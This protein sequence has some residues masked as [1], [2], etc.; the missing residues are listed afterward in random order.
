[1]SKELGNV[2]LGGGSGFIGKHLTSL[3]TSKGYNVTIIS[4]MPGASRISWTDLQTKGLPESTTAVINLAGQNVMDFTQRWTTGF[5][6]NVFNSRVK[7]TASLAEAIAKAPKRPKVFVAISGVGAYKPNDKEYTESSILENFDFFSK[8]CIE[9]EKAACL[10]KEVTDCRQVIIRSGVVLG[11]DG[12]M[13]KQLYLPFFLGLGG[14]VGSGMQYMPWIHIDDLTRLILFSIENNVEGVYN[15][16]APTPATNKEFS[17]AFA[18][19]LSRPAI[20][21]VPKFVF[22]A[23]LSEE[24]ANMITKGQK[25]LPQRYQEAGFTYNFPNITVACQDLVQ[26]K[27]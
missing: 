26:K 27:A 6:Q 16:V 5:K 18:G 10:P 17:N 11:R 22:N 20:F 25:V 13:I 23:L 7:T 4:R 8:L 2:L 21:P 12:G 14:P 3:L 15:G 1:M 24:R 19:A 9:W